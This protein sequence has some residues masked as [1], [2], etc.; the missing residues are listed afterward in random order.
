MGTNLIRAA[1][2]EIWPVDE[3]DTQNNAFK[4]ALFMFM[5]GAV[6]MVLCA[7]TQLY[8]RRNK[9]SKYYLKPYSGYKKTLDATPTPGI[10]RDSQQEEDTVMLNKS[11]S[12]NSASGLSASGNEW[13]HASNVHS[14]GNNE[15]HAPHQ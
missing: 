8:L 13:L 5:F 7:L 1:T 12:H 4:G 15:S 9:F 6:T 11:A 14:C 3:E 2:L 10:R